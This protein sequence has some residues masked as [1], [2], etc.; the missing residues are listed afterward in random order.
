MDIEI[1]QRDVLAT[2]DVQ[3]LMV[4]RISAALDRFD[5]H[6]VRVTVW[7]RDVNGPKGGGDH[8][9]CKI[10]VKLRRDEV[11][12]EERGATP[13]AAIAAAAEAAREAV[14]REVS[15]RKHGVGGGR[16]LRGAK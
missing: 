7:L 15:R 9:S 4:Q 12:V 3:E 1:A 16:S 13:E 8:N 5:P 10:E 6:I 11:I 2:G 14:R